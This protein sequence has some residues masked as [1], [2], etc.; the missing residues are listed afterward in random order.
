MELEITGPVLKHFRSALTCLSRLGQD[1]DFT[2]TEQRLSVS[3][4]NSSRTA[5]G[6]VHF[7]P[8]FFTSYSP[9]Q[10]TPSD[11]GDK[12][13][14]SV[15]A[16]SLL[17]TLRPRSA[18]TVESC[19]LSVH[20]S[21]DRN[22]HEP[23]VD[24]GECRIIVYLHCQHGVRK[25]H[26]L[27]YSQPAIQSWA[28]FDLN[29]APCHW[30]A[31]SR[32]L[33]DWMTHFHERASS[34]TGGGGGGGG[35]AGTDEVTFYCARQECRLRSFNDVDRS[36]PTN[37]VFMTRALSTEV[38][39]DTADF[40]TYHVPSPPSSSSSPSSASGVRVVTFAQ[41]E[42]KAII[43]LAEPLQ[44]PL[45]AHFSTGG[46]PIMFSLSANDPSRGGG[47]GGASSS[48]FE[49]KFV[50]A[51]TDFDSGG[52]GG[53]DADGIK[54]EKSESVA[55]QQQQQQQ[56]RGRTGTD[57]SINHRRG[58]GTPLFNA[59]TPSPAPEG[60]G[61]ARPLAE[62]DEFDAAF[63]DD[64]DLDDAFFADLDRA[65][66]Q[67][68]SQVQAQTQ[69]QT[70]PTTTGTT[71]TLASEKQQQQQPSEEEGEEGD[72]QLRSG[73]GKDFGGTAAWSAAAAP[74]SDDGRGGDGDGRYGREGA[75]E[76]ANGHDHDHEPDTGG[77]VGVGVGEG[78][79]GGGE[80]GGG[81]G[82][83]AA[84]LVGGHDDFVWED[85][86][87]GG[88]ETQLGPTQ[89]IRDDDDGGGGEDGS[90]GRAADDDSGGEGR[91]SVKRARWN[92]LGD[93]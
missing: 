58:G 47:G 72:V 86:A 34:G 90:G 85:P 19:T 63:D 44:V 35:G 68:M 91:R 23:G 59:P 9:L 24:S 80:G 78:G 8:S 15:N 64:A 16:K 53:G 45:T 69:T 60:K 62:E 42:F 21:D 40:D 66:Q 31:S 79:E 6:I 56:Q 51:T 57:G 54:R 22:H 48:S 41:K 32:V 84:V 52:S 43:N 5:F 73:V 13:R 11:E 20:D 36:G 27:T 70:R 17:S 89:V 30:S 4:V 7:Y 2:C 3:T 38:T 61:K 74:R 83:T 92:L 25:K 87:G 10:A 26:S 88:G 39:V 29:A 28:R 46:R 50:I 71:S 55:R 82:G 76:H 65:T 93:G 75:E 12:F 77:G 67:A 37:D 49:A 14:F 18:N 33:K 81:G 1:L